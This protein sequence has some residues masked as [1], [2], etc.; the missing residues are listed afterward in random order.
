MDAMLAVL[1]G[2]F[3]GVSDMSRGDPTISLHDVLM[4]AFAMMA[5][6]DPSLL[7]FE[8]RRIAEEHNLRS[9]FHIKDIPCD[10]QM[11]TRLDVVDPT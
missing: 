11:R 1:H 3:E 8:R 2:C 10:T 4:S 9:V 6:K 7:A 5:L